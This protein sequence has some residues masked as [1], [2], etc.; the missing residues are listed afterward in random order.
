MQ[1]FITAILAAAVLMPQVTITESADV[2]NLIAE[3]AQ[4]LKSFR[5]KFVERNGSTVTKGDVFYKRPDK[6]MLIYQTPKAIVANDTGELQ[7]IVCNGSKLWIY[8]PRIHVVS[9][10]DV[11]NDVTA[12]L[13]S[14]KG[15][16]RLKEDYYFN[17]YGRRATE[18]VSAF[19]AADLIVDDGKKKRT[20]ADNAVD[21]YLEQDERQAYHML[22]TPKTHMRTTDKAGFSQLHVWIDG[23][24]MIIR[25][26]GISTTRKQIE[27]VFTDIERNI[28][29]NND[30]F[31][32]SMPD[33][34][35]VV[36]NNLVT[37][38]KKKDEEK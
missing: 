4:S 33:N 22:L 26:L 37:A 27:Y 25:S 23:H 17:F 8:L 15:V 32:F 3:S 38:K 31:E 29:I 35:Q 24:G 18:T 21:S 28:D 5:G 16:L 10:Q 12:G 36:R 34:V 13:V 19:R 6:F 2:V 7:T 20:T 1:V 9:E 30:R 14:G 11:K